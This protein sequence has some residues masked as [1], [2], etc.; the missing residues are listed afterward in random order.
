MEKTWSIAI[1]LEL[2]EISSGDPLHSRVTIVNSNIFY[3]SKL[4]EERPFNVLPQRNDKCL[5]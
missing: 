3:I 1:E 5:S 4:L 2:A